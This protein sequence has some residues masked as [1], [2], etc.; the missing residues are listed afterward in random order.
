MHN[1][2]R[3]NRT[4]NRWINA[5]SGVHRHSGHGLDI[6]GAEGTARFHD[7]DERVDDNR[8]TSESTKREVTRTHDHDR[9]VTATN[10]EHPGT[11]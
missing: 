11:E 5:Q 6:D 7:L 1:A 2:P 3:I 10:D 4:S 8:Q 9:P